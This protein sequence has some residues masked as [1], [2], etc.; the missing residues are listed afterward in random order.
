MLFL[1]LY[2]HARKLNPFHLELYSL[3]IFRCFYSAYYN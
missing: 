2:A 1:L 3:I